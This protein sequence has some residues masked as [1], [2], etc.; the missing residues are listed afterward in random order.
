MVHQPPLLECGAGEPDALTPPPTNIRCANFSSAIACFSES[1]RREYRSVDVHCPDGF[2]KEDSPGPA[3]RLFQRG[4]EI[5]VVVPA[6]VSNRTKLRGPTRERDQSLL[7]WSRRERR[8][9]ADAR[10]GRDGAARGGPVAAP[11]SSPPA[12]IR[13]AE[14]VVGA[15]PLFDGRLK[16]QAGRPGGKRSCASLNAVLIRNLV[17]ANEQHSRQR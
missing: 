10:G 13:I 7:T 16:H 17:P 3:S 15:E 2:A 11:R 1:L 4:L 9:P 5:K 8:G 14:E 12:A 6:V